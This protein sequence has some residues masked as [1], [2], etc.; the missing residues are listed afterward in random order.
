VVRASSRARCVQHA[1]KQPGGH[2][3]TAGPVERDAGQLWQR[4]CPCLVQGQAGW[5]A[6][7]QPPAQSWSRCRVPAAAADDV[8]PPSSCSSGLGPRLG[9]GASGVGR[10]SRCSW[11]SSSQQV[12]RPASSRQAGRQRCST[13]AS[14]VQPGPSS[15]FELPSSSSSAGCSLLCVR[16]RQVG[17]QQGPDAIAAAGNS[18][19]ELSPSQQFGSPPS[20]PRRPSCARAGDAACQPPCPSRAAGRATRS[21]IDSHSYFKDVRFAAAQPAT[22]RAT[23]PRLRCP[24]ASCVSWRA[25]YCWVGVGRRCVPRPPAA[26][27]PACPPSALCHAGVAQDAGVPQIGC[28]CSNCTAT[29]QGR[30]PQQYAVSLALVDGPAAFIIDPR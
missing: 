27:A 20:L 21:P 6:P 12:G 7:Q 3:L 4:S 22:P 19:A 17:R 18:A 10:S 9:A 30:L 23:P 13:P 8:P 28:S 15:R 25:P 26:P 1:R 5:P 11:C 24:R 2:A 14:N 16:Q 29:R